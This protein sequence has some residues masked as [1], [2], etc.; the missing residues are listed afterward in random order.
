MRASVGFSAAAGRQ[1]TSCC[2]SA[3]SAGARAS[4]CSQP[5]PCGTSLH[6]P[7]ASHRQHDCWPFN[8]LTNELAKKA[9]R[10]IESYALRP[11]SDTSTAL[12]RKDRA[13][14][15]RE[16]P[17]RQCLRAL[18]VRT[19]TGVWRCRKSGLTRHFAASV[20]HS[21]AS[22]SCYSSLRCTAL[23]PERP[24]APPQRASRSNG[25]VNGRIAP[26][27]SVR[28][29]T[30]QVGSM[31]TTPGTT[32]IAE[33]LQ[34]CARKVQDC[35]RAAV[36][37]CRTHLCHCCAAA[38]RLCAGGL[39]ESYRGVRDAH[40]GIEL[41]ACFRGDGAASSG[42]LAPALPVEHLRTAAGGDVVHAAAAGHR[43]GGGR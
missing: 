6:L 7:A 1:R 20:S 25:F 23:I 30:D 42:P 5:S 34:R 37:H 41:Q 12:G 18:A 39:L 40:R 16:R 26:K 8:S 14:R 27:R 15:A 10:D 36:K 21:S 32:M 11:S 38:R 22:G 2:P 33:V 17:R 29:P 43:R 3:N 31:P 19:G 13:A 28:I 24:A 4:P 9:A 35:V